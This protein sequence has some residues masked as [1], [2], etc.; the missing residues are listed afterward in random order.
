MHTPSPKAWLPAATIVLA[1][2]LFAANAFAGD[3]EEDQEALVGKAI[4]TA[5]A[6]KVNALVPGAGKQM[7]SL[8]TCDVSGAGMSADFKFNV[9]GSD[10]LYW[11]QG[12]AKVAGAAVTDLKFTTMSP[13]LASVS[14]AKGV[15]LASN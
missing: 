14:A 11:V 15:K 8:D 10:G 5:A 2:A 9:I 3:C 4:A 12:H 1:A 6:A 7:I 13:N